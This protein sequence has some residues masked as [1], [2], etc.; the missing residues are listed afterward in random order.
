MHHGKMTTSKKKTKKGLG[1]R[2]SQALQES[3]CLSGK[4][5]P[6]SIAAS[7]MTGSFTTT[8]SVSCR[9]RWGGHSSEHG[10]GSISMKMISLKGI[11]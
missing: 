7:L 4:A 2:G 3:G 10:R 1:K 9:E 11:T 5:R 8:Q 6:L